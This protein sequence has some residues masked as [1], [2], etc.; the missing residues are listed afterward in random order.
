MICFVETRTAHPKTHNCELRRSKESK[1]AKETEP[2]HHFQNVN[3]QIGEFQW[4]GNCRL[5]NG[6]DNLHKATRIVG[7]GRKYSKRLPNQCIKCYIVQFYHCTFA[8]LSYFWGLLPEIFAKFTFYQPM[9]IFVTWLF[10]YYLLAGVNF[11]FYKQ[12]SRF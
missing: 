7:A 5:V 4:S 10:F 3:M 1:E 9:Y 8:Q 2:E 12:K 11:Q 6:A